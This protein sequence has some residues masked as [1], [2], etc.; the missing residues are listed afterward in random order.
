VIG[1]REISRNRDAEYRFDDLIAAEQFH[2]WFRARRRLVLWALDRYAPETHNLLEIGCG[3]GFVLQ[4]LR[5]RNPQM[6][7]AA[8]DA[9]SQ[10]LA[11]AQR[12]LSRVHFFRADVARLPVM[13]VFDTITALDV[14]E[15]VADDERA[16]AEMFGS[17]RPGGRLVLTVPQHQWLWSKVDEFSC[18]K[19][20]YGRD[21]LTAKVQAAGFEILRSTSF[22]TATLPFAV[23]ARRRSACG[24]RRFD[25]SAELRIS[26]TISTALTLLLMPEWWLVRA[27]LSM[28][29]GSSLLLVAKR[30]LA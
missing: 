28:P 21:D 25:P 23:V 4:S 22:F 20:R 1:A 24:G 9:S 27:G 16:L 18:H 15:H 2:F 26:R 13:P 3:T 8:C 17:L 29:A 30:P 7:L 19:R 14:I 6:H 10:A 11:H 12:R 5:Q